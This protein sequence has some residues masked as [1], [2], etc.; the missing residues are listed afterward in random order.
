MAVVLVELVAPPQLEADDERTTG[1]DV[2]R[3][4]RDQRGLGPRWR[5]QRDVPG[6]D[7]DVEDLTQIEGGQ[8]GADPRDRRAPAAGGREHRR[9][10][11]HPDDGNPA[12]GELD[13]H[14]PGAASGI[15]HRRG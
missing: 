5:E 2:A 7:H 13:G 4:S 11:V 12:P 8:V 15:E 9:I 1:R 10:A 14:P 3:A 6:H